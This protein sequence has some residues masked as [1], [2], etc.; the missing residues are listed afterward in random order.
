MTHTTELKTLEDRLTDSGWSIVAREQ[1]FYS[2]RGRTIGDIDLL[3]VRFNINGINMIYF[4]EKSGRK[5]HLRKAKK[6]IKKGMKYIIDTY[7]P[8]RLWGMYSHKQEI[9]KIGAYEK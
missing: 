8:Y 4:E 3:A 6:Q 7:N 5:T 9:E 1:E 2:S